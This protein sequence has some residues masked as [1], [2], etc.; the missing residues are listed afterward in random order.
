MIE[1]FFFWI[2]PVA[3]RPRRNNTFHVTFNVKWSFHGYSRKE[4]P[5]RQVPNKKEQWPLPVYWAAA[6]RSVLIHYLYPCSGGVFKCSA[7]HYALCT[8]IDRQSLMFKDHIWRCVFC[9]AKMNKV[10]FVQIIYT[11]QNITGMKSEPLFCHKINRTWSSRE[12]STRSA[13]AKAVKQ[14]S[15]YPTN[16]STMETSSSGGMASIAWGAASFF[17][18][19]MTTGAG[20]ELNAATQGGQPFISDSHSC[21]SLFWSAQPAFGAAEPLDLL[22]LGTSSPLTL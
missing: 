6:G 20:E 4:T 16:S 13:P 11:K 15:A 21:W 3:R 7:C 5:G 8:Q 9:L 10:M 2:D 22:W 14:V 12:F 19:L 1:Y 18:L 17:C